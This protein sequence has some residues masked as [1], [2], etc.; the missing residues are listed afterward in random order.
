MAYGDVQI[1][2]WDVQYR[3]KMVHVA[4]G[5]YFEVVS[6]TQIDANQVATDA[7][8]QAALDVLAANGFTL[9]QGLK[10]CQAAQTITPTPPE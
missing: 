4:S 3:V 10:I 5:G 2:D 1:Q 8:V 7:A 9:D 6:G